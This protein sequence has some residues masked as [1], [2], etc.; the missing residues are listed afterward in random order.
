MARLPLLIRRMPECL[1]LVGWDRK[2]G[3]ISGFIRFFLSSLSVW[4]LCLPFLSYEM[5]GEC[6]DTRTHAHFTRS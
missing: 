1:Q 5:Y 2:G 4:L 3:D 6:T